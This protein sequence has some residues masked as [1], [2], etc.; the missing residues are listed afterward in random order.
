MTAHYSFLKMHGAGNDFVLIDATKNTFSP[1]FDFSKAAEL[2]CHR[3]FGVG[4]DG[5]LTLEP[6]LVADLRMRMWNPD[7]TEDMCGNGL[8]CVAALGWRQKY[9]QNAHFSV[10]TIAGI[11]QIEALTD[12]IFTAT[13]GRPDFTPAQI[14]ITVENAINY[15]LVVENRTFK[16]NSV[17]TGSTHTVIFLEEPLSEN[18]F[19]FFSPKIENHPLFP[20]RTSIMWAVEKEKNHFLIRIWE[21]GVG[22]TLACGT[23]AS[24][25]GAI[26]K[27]TGR[28]ENEI[29]VE[30]KGGTLIARWNAP[31]EEIFLTGPATYLFEGIWQGEL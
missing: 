15:D 7:G 27:V 6:S 9:V 25:V 24:A 12:E 11:R 26:A 1:N 2:L 23:G 16:A 29:F 4:G 30:S 3:H 22:E 17:T 5:L 28:G 31:E 8:R 10:E 18:D 21:R 14:P 20:D 19:Q 13:M